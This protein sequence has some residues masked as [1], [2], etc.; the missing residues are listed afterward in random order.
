M[1]DTIIS[2]ALQDHILMIYWIYD[3]IN[4]IFPGNCQ[5]CGKLLT[6]AEPVICIGCELK[7][8][9]TGFSDD[10]ENPVSQL[11]WGRTQILQATSLFKFEKGSA[12]RVLLHNLKY[13]GIKRNGKYLGRLLG[14]DLTDT[15]FGDC[16]FIAPVPLHRRKKRSRGFNQSELIAA[17]VG[18]SIGKPVIKDY[19]I[20]TIYT[21]SQTKKGRFERFKNVELK[22]KLNP[23]YRSMSGATCLLID[24]VVTTGSTLEGCSEAILQ[25]TDMKV[26]A[27]TVAYA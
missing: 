22:F 8:P 21:D 4:I 10:P 6:R 25:E 9:R 7:L 19:L 15:V 18:K 5:V 12:Y 13:K 2:P 17:G 26:M 14:L 27:A 1:Q 20:R 24:D 16:D 3:F 23:A 11:F